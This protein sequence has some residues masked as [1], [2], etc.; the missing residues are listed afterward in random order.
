VRIVRDEINRTGNQGGSL[1]CDE[2]LRGLRKL[3]ND[4]AVEVLGEAATKRPNSIGQIASTLLSEVD[5]PDGLERL[6]ALAIENRDQRIGIDA[7]TG[8]GNYHSGRAVAILSKAYQQKPEERILLSMGRTGHPDAI[9][10][11]L[12]VVLDDEGTGAFQHEAANALALIGPSSVPSLLQGWAKVKDGSV[13]KY[14]RRA[15]LRAMSGIADKRLLPVWE[16]VFNM[17]APE[18]RISSWGMHV[19][20]EWE[21]L[22]NSICD[23]MLKMGRDALPYL[24]GLHRQEQH[25]LLRKKLFR[26]IEQINNRKSLDVAK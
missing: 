3:G 14:A 15:L 4:K 24:G 20:P 9:P 5:N 17:A 8:L 16:D 10:I 12:G 7:I 13:R 19:Q 6:G 23:G 26:V 22:L 25:D 11:L 1:I 21:V 2:A 18:A